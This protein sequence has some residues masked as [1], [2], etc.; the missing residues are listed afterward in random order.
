M[1]AVK[2]KF[3]SPR[4]F[5]RE[6]DRMVEHLR[7]SIED[8]EPPVC[9]ACQLETKWYRSHRMQA[10][11]DLIAHFFSCP[12]CGRIKEVKTKMHGQ[13][14]KDKAPK[15]S[16]P[17]PPGIELHKRVRSESIRNSSQRRHQANGA[18]AG[19]HLDQPDRTSDFRSIDRG[20]LFMIVPSPE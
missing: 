6:R 7:Q 4:A 8:L 1:I 20:F 19:H 14:G 17:P 11:P 3:D 13:S 5:F 18:R 9:D 16:A 12:A 15:L 2:N 10:A